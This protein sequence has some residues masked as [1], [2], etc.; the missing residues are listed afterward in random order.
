MLLSP[1]LFHCNTSQSEL[2]CSNKCPIGTFHMSFGIR[3]KSPIHVN[4]LNIPIQNFKY[5]KNA[6][7]ACAEITLLPSGHPFGTWVPMSMLRGP[8]NIGTSAFN[9]FNDRGFEAKGWQLTLCCC[10]TEGSGVHSGDNSNHLV[11]GAWHDVV[12][13]VNSLNF[14]R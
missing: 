8:K 7:N 3:I 9:C 1:L 2:N 13:T 5:L 14:A 4:T 11:N 6:K 10:W 12:A